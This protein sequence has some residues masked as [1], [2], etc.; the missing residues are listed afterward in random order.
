VRRAEY[1]LR[2]VVLAAL[3]VWIANDHV[4]KAAFASWWTGKLSDVASLVVFPLVPYAAVD[5]WRA[6]RGLPP[7]PMATLGFWIVATGLV[8]VTIKTLGPAADAYR[9]GLGLAQWPVRALRAGELV[10][11]SPVHL[12]EDPTDLLTLPAL[13]VP[14]LVVR[15][16]MRRSSGR[17]ISSA[18]RA[19]SSTSAAA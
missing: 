2:P 3:I 8:M 4:L 12:A 13:L 19:G 7:P 9:W 10:S 5:L 16:E 6:R 17:T 1:L 11:I 15:H 18:G 14:W